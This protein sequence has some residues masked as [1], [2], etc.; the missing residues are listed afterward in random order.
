MKV[1]YAY[2]S[3]IVIIKLF[4]TYAYLCLY[5][6]KLKISQGSKTRTDDH[7]YDEL[8]MYSKL[9]V[10][11]TMPAKSLS[12]KSDKVIFDTKGI[13]PPAYQSLPKPRYESCSATS[14]AKSTN[15]NDYY[16][17]EDARSIKDEDCQFSFEKISKEN[18]ENS[19]QDE[20]YCKLYHFK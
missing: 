5:N 7:I 20:P 14:I 17:E 15:S 8:D 18:E 11:T 9:N 19:K 1:L 3:Y 12:P 13:E 4:Y 10:K 6:R 16:I 2:G